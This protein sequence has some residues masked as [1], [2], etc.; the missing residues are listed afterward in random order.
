MKESELGK[1]PR[2]QLIGIPAAPGSLHFDV[3]ALRQGG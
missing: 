3:A 1:K 2:D